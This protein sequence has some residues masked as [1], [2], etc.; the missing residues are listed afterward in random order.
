MEGVGIA[1]AIKVMKKLG[2]EVPEFIVV[3]GISDDADGSAKGAPAPMNFFETR[4]ENVYPDDRQ[5]MAALM[6]V[7]LV[8]RAIMLHREWKYY[9]ATSNST[10]SFCQII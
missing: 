3:K 1:T 6:S 2:N 8:T 5:V 4:Y 9:R 7:T 10:W